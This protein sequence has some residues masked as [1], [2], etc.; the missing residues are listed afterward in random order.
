MRNWIFD[1]SHPATFPL[2]P[3]NSLL[4]PVAFPPPPLRFHNLTLNGVRGAGAGEGAEVEEENFKAPSAVKN[5]PV[6]P[7]VSYFFFKAQGGFHWAPSPN[8]STGYR[9]SRYSR[10]GRS[11]PGSPKRRLMRSLASGPCQ[12][13]CPLLH[14][15]AVDL[16]SPRWWKFRLGFYF[17][18]GKQSNGADMV[19]VNFINE[20]ILKIYI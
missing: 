12:H 19:L 5:K 1:F 3:P 20:K 11:G 2:A 9:S 16:D 14:H 7:P 6:P 4:D 15:P 13:R 10:T 8:P 17:K 18:Q